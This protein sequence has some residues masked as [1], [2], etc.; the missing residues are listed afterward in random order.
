MIK[1]TNTLSGKIEK[2]KPINEGEVGIYACGPTV[3]DFVHIGNLRAYIFVDTLNRVLK[4]NN[5]QTKLVMNIT[6]VGHL[7]S[8]EDEGEDKIELSAK[9]Q[10]KTAW[11]ISKFYIDEFLSDIEQLKILIPDIMP[12][13]TDHIQEQ[14]E[15]I[16]KIEEKEYAYKIK[17]GLYFNTSKF[18]DYGKLGQINLAGQK[19]GARIGVV[20]GKKNPSDFA[21]WKFSHKG[22]DAASRRQM[23]WDSPWGRG[24]PGWHIEC[25]AMSIKYL[26]QPFDIHT[27]GVDH[28]PVHHENEIAQAEIA[29]GKKLANYFLHNEHLLV[30]NKRMAKSTGNFYTIKDLIKRGFEPRAFRHLCLSAHYR[31]KLNFTWGSLQASQNAIKRIDGLVEKEGKEDIEAKKRAIEIV[32][33]DLAT[34]KMLAFL[35][36]EKNPWLWKA[37]ESVHGIKFGKDK[38]ELTKEQEELIFQREKLRGEGKFTKADAIR[39]QLEKQGIELKD[40]KL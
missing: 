38:I 24:F 28:I 27:G 22:G 3:Y 32:S 18:P 15:M 5:Y 17:D 39:D 31:D 16:K 26:G 14:I 7:V 2:F 36:Q 30:N 8:D 34:P 11:E 37:L 4:A 29:G 13:A 25:S 6:D 33:D 20:A 19:E 12:K 10:H 35:E 9:R 23:E 1:L 40:T 21:L